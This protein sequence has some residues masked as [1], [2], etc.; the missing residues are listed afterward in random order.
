[1]RVLVLQEAQFEALA[2]LLDAAVKAVGLRAVKDTAALL[3]AM[4]AAEKLPDLVAE[5]TV[6]EPPKGDVS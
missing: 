6:A 2:G 5:Q 1:M 4:E 3:A